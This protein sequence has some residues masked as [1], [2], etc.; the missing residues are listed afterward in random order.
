MFSLLADVL[1]GATVVFGLATIWVIVRSSREYAKL[2]KMH[3]EV[4]RFDVDALPG[5]GKLTQEEFMR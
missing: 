3:I 4:P 2:S 5:N 1:N